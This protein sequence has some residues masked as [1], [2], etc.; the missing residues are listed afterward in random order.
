MAESKI[1]ITIQTTVKA[2]ID[3]VWKC[4]ITP[5][6]IIKW[7]SASNDW[8]TTKAVNDFHVGRKFSYRMEAKDGSMGFD[9]GGIYDSITD[10]KQI[11]YTLEDGRTATITFSVIGDEEIEV[12]E[13]FDA[14]TFN[15]IEMQ[16]NGWQAILNSFRKYAEHKFSEQ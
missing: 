7:N 16:Q 14:E 8:H 6:D 15:P 10:H 9:F 2:P 3:I 11:S 5:A 13:S 12:V 4:W 1:V